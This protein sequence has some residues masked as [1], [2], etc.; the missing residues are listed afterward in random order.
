MEPLINKKIIDCTLTTSI[1][2]KS[3]MP[4]KVHMSDFH[5]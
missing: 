3:V 5:W 4:F 2:I 1:P